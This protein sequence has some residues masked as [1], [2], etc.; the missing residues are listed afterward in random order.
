MGRDQLRLLEQRLAE[1]T[2]EVA[3]LRVA[4]AEGGAYANSSK[5][6]TV[7]AAQGALSPA[8]ELEMERAR[9][10]HL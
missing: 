10:V 7:V 3:K 8:I 9:R 1:K 2:R 6:T 5:L 4:A